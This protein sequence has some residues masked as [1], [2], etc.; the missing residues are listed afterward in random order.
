[1]TD[2]PW[3]LTADRQP[4]PDTLVLGWFEY[5]EIQYDPVYL[6]PDAHPAPRD[7]WYRDSSHDRCDAPP[8]YWLPLSPPPSG[9]SEGAA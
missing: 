1:M 7:C 4:E 5:G 9:S 2:L 3:V 8:E 6:A